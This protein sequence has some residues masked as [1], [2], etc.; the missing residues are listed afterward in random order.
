[1]EL[2]IVEA[3][4]W[5]KSIEIEK[6]TM[7][8]GSA[9]SNDIYLQTESI[10]PVQM[11]IYYSP[12]LPSSC[13][14][15]N[16]VGSLTI[17]NLGGEIRIA[18]FQ[19]VDVQDGDEIQLGEYKLV[20]SLPLSVEKVEKS[21]S[22]EAALSFSDPVLKPGQVLEGRLT[23]K[24]LGEEEECQFDVDF[25][26]F[27]ED[28]V[29]I[30]PIPL[31]YPGAEEQIG[32]QLYHHTTYPEA[33]S[34]N[35]RISVIAQESY[36]G[37][38]LNIN[39]GIY[40]E[41]VFSQLMEIEDDLALQEIHPEKV[42]AETEPALSSDVLKEVDQKEQE[43]EDL[44]ETKDEVEEQ[45][46]P[47]VQENGQVE[48]K[49]EPLINL[50]TEPEPVSVSEPAPDDISIPDLIKDEPEAG[51]VKPPQPIKQKKKKS[52]N[53]KKTKGSAPKQEVVELQVDQETV[54]PSVNEETKE[55]LV[56]EKEEI[57]KPVRV[58][59]EI[60]VTEKIDLPKAEE[61]VREV[62]KAPER[63]NPARVF[64]EKPEMDF[65]SEEEAEANT[66]SKGVDLS[67]FKVARDQPDDFWD[68]D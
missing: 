33:G 60:K 67:G 10:A 18:P 32:I 34:T 6:A 22:I 55:A 45:S 24:N 57:E 13:R 27:P 40:V 2:K 44:S 49:A 28:C 59:K 7:S 58:P 12:Y 11:Q 51:P 14:L 66:D 1:M 23:L 53:K 35:L 30:D 20:F 19:K 64:K 56:S 50:E 47:A 63:P 26:G 39:Q 54:I 21:H 41:P 17:K 52:K 38:R 61:P 25:Y 65:W 42:D 16:L 48:E 4:G 43:V 3:Q 68:E 9:P 31:M 15:L 62:S 36:P 46:I 37:E 29:Q 5:T 8:V